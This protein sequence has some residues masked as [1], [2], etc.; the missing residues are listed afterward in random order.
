MRKAASLLFLLPLYWIVP[1]CPA[2]DTVKPGSDKARWPIKT[3]LP[4]GTD[5]SKP[6]VPI[7]LADLLA[8]APAADAM[9]AAFENVRYPK[10]QGAKYA[11]GQIVSTQG[12]L[13]LVAGEPDGDY[14]IQLSDTPDTFDNCLVVE[15]PKDDPEFISKDPALI[16][17]AKTVRAW[18]VTSLKLS[19]DPTGRV[20]PL[21][22]PAYVMVTGQLFFD[23][24]HQAA[25]GKGVYRGK[26]IGGKQ[27][28]SK[29]AWEIHP[30]TKI[31]FAPKP[32]K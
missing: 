3:S 21:T 27:L 20:I 11:E 26:S 4:P 30:I 19:K 28:P 17:A 23:A 16:E 29:T 14:H 7:S 2:A 32:A 18:V 15:V 6:G 9:T 31:A 10:T 1:V 24:E 25:M 8:L 13:R 5:L 22:N 12:Y